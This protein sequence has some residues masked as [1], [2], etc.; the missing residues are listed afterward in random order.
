M[1]CPKTEHLLQEYFADDLSAMS[2]QELDRHLQRCE[3]CREELEALL[4]ARSSIEQW[5][6]QRV[7][8]WD[9]GLELFRREHGA[10]RHN[11]GFWS[12]WQWFP[13]AASF[14]MLCL[15]IFNT[16][17]VSSDTGITIS[18]GGDA[19]GDA[20][21]ESALARFQAEQDAEMQAL[22]TRVEAR[23]DSNNVQLLEAVMQQTQESTAENL[24]RIYAY[25]EQQRLQDLQA[26]RAGYQELVDS[27]YQTIRSLEQLAQYVSYDGSPHR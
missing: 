25:F 2:S 23:Q 10:P 13:T 5:Q 15:M 18:F 26:M 6:E 12:R 20:Q 21:F 24:D 11:T 14:A 9:R 7:P 8:H 27:D 19:G 4:Q 1:S 3:H 17:V 16:T 22:I